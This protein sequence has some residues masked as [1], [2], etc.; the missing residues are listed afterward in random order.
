FSA[1]LGLIALLGA[2][3]E[4]PSEPAEEASQASREGD[5]GEDGAIDLGDDERSD[6]SDDAPPLA[7]I[8]DQSSSDTQ[9]GDS[10]G[11]EFDL[12]GLD[13]ET[14]DGGVDQHVG[15]YVGGG[16]IGAEG[17][18]VE[19]PDRLLTLMVPPG[20]LDEVTFISI[21]V[22]SADDSSDYVYELEP[23]GL[24][25]S[26]PARVEW[27]QSI[28]AL[29]DLD[30][31]EDGI[32]MFVMASIGEESERLG[33]ETTLFD[34]VAGVVSVSGRLNHFSALALRGIGQVFYRDLRPEVPIVGEPWTLSSSF[35]WER[36]DPIGDFDVMTS[37]SPTTRESTVSIANP[38]RGISVNEV[39]P[40]TSSVPIVTTPTEITIGES[41]EFA[42]SASITCAAK[43]RRSY[44]VYWVW[45]EGNR[46]SESEVDYQP[47][48]VTAAYYGEADCQVV[49]DG[50]EV[51]DESAPTAVAATGGGYELLNACAASGSQEGDDDF[52]E[53]DVCP[54]GRLRVIAVPHEYPFPLL[55]FG[56]PRLRMELAGESVPF[57]QALLANE[58]D[59]KIFR[60]VNDTDQVQ[61]AL[62]RVF[63]E[64][65]GQGSEER[66]VAYYD[67]DMSVDCPMPDLL[68]DDD[69][70]ETANV[71][72]SYPASYVDLTSDVEDEDWFRL[73][74]MCNS[75]LL[76]LLIEPQTED[77]Y[78]TPFDGRMLVDDE[79]YFRLA[80]PVYDEDFGTITIE[81]TIP[82]D[83]VPEE[84]SLSYF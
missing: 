36:A 5:L 6:L 24:T 53:V 79:S 30:P 3:S 21:S 29:G 34:A 19:S 35:D 7:D 80:D 62:L 45:R 69:T 15:H 10:T 1:W 42:E 66:Y 23:D 22:G 70:P 44:Q 57:L 65:N 75:G 37:L 71:I 17:G 12:G 39:D 50:L 64:N 26:V 78:V 77:Y 25:F 68:E 46:V 47:S 20:A 9:S 58:V 28:E 13:V 18:V 32:P 31:E 49:P 43:G 27:E 52:F 33:N 67:L 74:G 11:S 56:F 84:G 14:R 60:A 59:F 82:D 38:N 63:V 76:N 54:G 8:R 83:A 73:D 40:L 48:N 55:N 2:C 81:Y 4:A 16:E 61:T 72:G 51:N 41:M